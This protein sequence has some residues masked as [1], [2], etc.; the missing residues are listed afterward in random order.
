MTETEGRLAAFLARKPEAGAASG[1]TSNSALGMRVAAELRQAVTQAQDRSP[2]SLQVHLGPSEIGNACHRQIAGKLAGLP[3]TNHVSDP[4]P[5]F[6]GTATHDRLANAVEAFRPGRWQAERK[7]TP[8]EGH[9]GTADL[10]DAE[11]RAVIDHKVLGR[12]SHAKIVAG[13]L[14]RHYYVQLLLYGLG[15]MRAGMP[16]ERVMLAA[17]SRGGMLP[18]LYVWDHELTAED[19]RLLEHVLLSELPY[20]KAWAAAITAGSATLRDVPIGTETPECY[21][22]PYW[23]PEAKVNPEAGGCPGVPNA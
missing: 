1:I 18:D 4:W 5:S 15:Y 6:V 13:K 23:R 12:T 19:M 17:W 7:V 9:S 22:C 3:A 20:R 2:R 10:Y 21:F 11:L 14:P 16:V 8:I